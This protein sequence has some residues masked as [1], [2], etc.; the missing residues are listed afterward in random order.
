M[1][2]AVAAITDAPAR[3]SAPRTSSAEL[4]A[5]HRQRPFA[6]LTSCARSRRPAYVAG[7]GKSCGVK[8][9][10]DDAPFVAALATQAALCR[11]DMGTVESHG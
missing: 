9:E 10:R 1:R 3:R 2:R 8:P 4:G 7:F 5:R 6:N 11:R